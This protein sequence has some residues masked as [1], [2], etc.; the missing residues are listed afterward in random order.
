MPNQVPYW[1]LKFYY[2]VHVNKQKA[3]WLEPVTYSTFRKR[4]ATWM[5]LHDAIYSP[6]VE[7]QVRYHKGTPIQDNIR[8]TAKLREENI[9]I[10]D[11]HELEKVEL[12][13]QPKS[14]QKKQVQ[15]RKEN[16]FISFFKRWINS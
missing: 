12:K 16:R 2:W 1:D 3:L 6:R 4:L 14:K 5:N 9:Q 15:P 13:Y 10:L 11:L 8:R 7:W